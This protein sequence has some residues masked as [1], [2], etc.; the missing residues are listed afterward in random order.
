MW[1]ALGNSIT[2]GR[3]STTDAQ[4]RWTDVASTLLSDEQI[5]FLNLGIGGNCVCGGGLGPTAAQRFEN[6]ILQQAGVEGVIVYVG[7]NDIGNST[8]IEET[9]RSLKAHFIRFITLAHEQ[10]LP[11]FVCTVTPFEGHS[12]FTLEHEQLRQRFNEWLR[13]EALADGV[14]DLDKVLSDPVTPRSIPAAL[15]DNDG[16]HPSPLG[17]RK[18]GEAIADYIQRYGF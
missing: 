11:V 4:N 3:G 1:S 9:L 2:D 5:G 15:Q 10:G 12:Y 16:L 6:D 13:T 18:I 8:N 7:V 17:H 14:I